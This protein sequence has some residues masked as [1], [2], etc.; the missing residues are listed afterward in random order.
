MTSLSSQLESLAFIAEGSTRR[1][2]IL[3][4]FL[5]LEIFDAKY[6][7][8]KDESSDLDGKIKYL[9]ESAGPLGY[10]IRKLETQKKIEETT[11]ELRNPGGRLAKA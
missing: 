2:E 1:K 11:M 10:E 4:K 8:A 3:A 6:K 7:I 9:T 5:D